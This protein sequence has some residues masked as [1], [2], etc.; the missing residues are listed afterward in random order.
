MS[1]SV[2]RLI[3][4][5]KHGSIQEIHE[6]QELLIPPNISLLLRRAHVSRTISKFLSE[7]GTV[8]VEAKK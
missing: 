3:Y 5:D 4:K 6:F 8:T 7:G 1:H 2:I